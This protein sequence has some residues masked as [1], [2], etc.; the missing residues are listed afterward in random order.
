MKTI[1]TLLASVASLVLLVGC[2]DPHPQH[3]GGHGDHPDTGAHGGP[4]VEVGDHEAHLE[5]LHD[6]AAGTLT[7]YALD[8]EARNAVELDEAP[9]LNLKVDG[10]PLQ[11]TMTATNGGFTVS[12]DALKSEPEGR[13]VVKIG[14]TSHQVEIEH[15]DHGH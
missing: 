2:G 14:G 5:I 9:G 4:L 11:L 8:G 15:D 12:H 13:V 10:A 1:Q 6:G 7:V 3:H